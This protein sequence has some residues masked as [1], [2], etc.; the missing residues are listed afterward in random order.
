MIMSIILF[1]LALVSNGVVC[2]DKAATHPARV[3]VVL[4]DQHFEDGSTRE[5]GLH[6]YTQECGG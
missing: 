4:H 6:L 1:F 3:L 5:V 2:H